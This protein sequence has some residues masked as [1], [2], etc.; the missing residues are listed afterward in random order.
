MPAAPNETLGRSLSENVLTILCL[1]R[2]HGRLVASMIDA[3]LFDSDVH[4]LLAR[5]ALDYWQ[6]HNRPPGKNHAGDLVAEVIDDPRHPHHRVMK[7]M[8]LGMIALYDGDLNTAYV[9]DQ[10]RNFLRLQEFRRAVMESSEILS[11]RQ[12]LA[13]SEVEEMWGRIL[14]ARQID[15]DPGLR[16]GDFQVMIDWMEKRSVEF[17]TGVVTLNK[18]G[19]VPARGS[20]V[21][22]LG[23]KGSGKSWF[24][25]DVG[26]RAWRDGKRV[27]HITLENRPPLVLQRYYQSLFAVP[28]TANVDLKRVSR[29]QRG[30]DNRFT[31]I[32]EEY[33]DPEF[34]L[35]SPIIASELA[36]HLTRFGLRIDNL[37]I[38]SFPRGSLTMNKLRSY[39][40]NMEMA[41]NFSPDLCVLDYFGLMQTDPK[42]PVNS[43]GHAFEDFCGLLE[44]RN[45]AGVTAQQLTRKGAAAMVAGS[46]QVAESWR[47]VGAADTVL[48]YSSSD[49]E[50][51]RGLG[52]L[53]VGHSRE[54]DDHWTSLITQHYQFGQ[55][56][57][58]SMRLPRGYNDFVSDLR[59]E[60][61]AEEEDESAVD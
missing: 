5:R 20:V 55:Y 11:S 28:R 27:V 29:I 33:A 53:A 51:A 36:A 17:S 24:L 52:R 46:T 60:E 40:D 57:L 61:A 50:R 58:D 45:M 37:V 4:Q 25:V 59:R 35:D 22:Y 7:D 16:L 31:G 14:R 8:L 54:S 56:C 43:L 12:H 38:K 2:D 23:A 19:V 3:E 9:L 6:M 1:D 49:A 10:L 39:L 26:K 47:M 44:E 34:A 32:E 21:L 15:F 13:L 18:A 48:I 42:D 41:E 30:R